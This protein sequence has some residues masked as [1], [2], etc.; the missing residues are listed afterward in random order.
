MTTQ[1]SGAS[2]DIA[3]SLVLLGA[4]ILAL[5]AANSP[6]SG[7]YQTALATPISVSVGDLVLSDTTKN[8]IKNALMAVFFLY[9]GL[10]IKAEFMQGAL[11]DRERATLPF[12]AAF[13]GLVVP[14]AIYLKV[15]GFDPALANGWAIPAATDIAFAVGVVGL[16][17]ARVPPALKVFLLAVAI[18][19]DMAAILIIAAF[20]TEQILPGPLL[21]AGL[22]LCG[23]LALNLANVAR[24]S[25]YM[26]LGAALWLAV[27]K[28]GINPTL[29]GVATAL[30]V[31]LRVGDDHLLYRLVK[32]LKNTVL[33]AIMPIFAL[34]N[35]GVALGALASRTCSIP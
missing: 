2:S 4:A 21:Y 24:L 14:A 23:L 32:A 17:G 30:F 9:V 12:V 22:C 35:A 8:W 20:Y 29:A 5:V 33:F 28:S 27:L 7:F 1:N 11:A 31:P 18:I 6:L 16:L 19:D 3:A 13:G 26:L 10:E 15:V 25:P 34:A